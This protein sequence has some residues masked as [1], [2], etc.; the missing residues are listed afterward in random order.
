M[1]AQ[2]GEILNYDNQEMYINTEPLCSYLHDNKI[3]WKSVGINTGCWRGYYGQWEIKEKKLMLTKLDIFSK[4]GPNNELGFL[5]PGK[6]EV[7]AD[8]FTG[9]IVIP[10]GKLLEYVHMGYDSVYEEQIELG[11]EKG[12]LKRE[13][14]KSKSH[15]AHRE[16]TDEEKEIQKNID[17]TFSEVLDDLKRRSA[18]DKMS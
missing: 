10:K 5:F 2:I 8:W 15:L 9:L 11:F 7:F 17:D 18:E 12:I 14:V 6:S 1:T 16:L 13:E 3:N 4:E